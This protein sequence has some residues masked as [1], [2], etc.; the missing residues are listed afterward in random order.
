MTDKILTEAYDKL[1]AIEESGDI[2]SIIDKIDP[3]VW[4]ALTDIADDRDEFEEYIRY[5]AAT[6]DD[7]EADGDRY[8]ND[9]I[10]GGNIATGWKL[11]L[12]NIDAIYDYI[13]GANESINEE[14]E[15]DTATVWQTVKQSVDTVN[16]TAI[17]LQ[18]ALTLSP[19]EQIDA[20][21]A[22]EGAIER[23]KSVTED[24]GNAITSKFSDDDWNNMD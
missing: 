12:Q 4:E 10:R 14:G 5:N 9:N 17:N 13:T 1:K 6:E 21:A 18:N 7:G 24:L 8:G 22:F 20:L 16:D 11:V 19:A 3:D 23:V 2:E 15:L